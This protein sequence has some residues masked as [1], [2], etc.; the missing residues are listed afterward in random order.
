[1][2]DNHIATFQY[3]QNL[4]NGILKGNLFERSALKLFN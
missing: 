1:M 3:K 4:E 2:N